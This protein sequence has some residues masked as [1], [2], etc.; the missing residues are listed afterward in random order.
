LKNRFL[1]LLT[2]TT[3]NL[4]FETRETTTKAPFIRDAMNLK[5]WLTY[6]ILALLPCFFV[7]IFN[8]G[9]QSIIF[10]SKNALLKTYYLNANV[11]I[12]AY[13]KFIIYNDLFFKSLVKG[14]F[15]TI[16]IVLTS[17]IVGGFWEVFFAFIRKKDISEGFFVTGLL[18][19]LILPPNLPL[20]M[21]AVG[22][23]FGVIVGKE[24]FGGTGY[25]IFNPA[26]IGR[27]FI[28]FAFPLYMSGNIFVPNS[29]GPN[30]F[31]SNNFG[32]QNVDGI[33][34]QTAL[35]VYNIPQTIKKYHIDKIEN[36]SFKNI[37]P[38]K[39]DLSQEEIELAQNYISL[40]NGTP[41][42][43]F[44]NSNLFWGNK[45]GSI[46]ETSIFAILL[47]MIFMLY[48]KVASFRI[49]LSF[50]IGAFLTASVLYLLALF[51]PSLPAIFAL[52]V[53]KQFLMG[54][55]MF[56]IVFMATDPVTSPYMN[57][58]K[59]AFGL[60]GGFL[61]MIIRVFNPAYVEGTMLAIIFMNMLAP[62]FD[63][64]AINRFYK[65]KYA[66]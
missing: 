57:S 61:V 63:R 10:S 47:G 30:N 28:Y 1:S 59:I 21:V 39:I 49:M 55:L 9:L 29:F 44:T 45:L 11:S 3:K 48:K 5:K 33:T 23:S 2:N 46:G 54:G 52:P 15:I 17:Y 64:I 8:T 24:I 56:G 58:A 18:Y 36:S 51:F 26:L 38:K 31:G 19:A 40:K 22:I 12:T 62:L 50:F 25:N 32:N 13:I 6:V 7:S 43:I 27:I 41:M 20:W 60:L 14:L 65:K 66:S 34:S 42:T 37:T 16:P 35:S 4:L 53:Y